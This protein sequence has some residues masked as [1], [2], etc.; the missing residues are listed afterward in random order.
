MVSPTGDGSSPAPIDRPLLEFLQTRLAS[1]QQVE[2][3][4]ITGVSG[5]LVLRVTL[6]ATYYPETVEE[7][8]LLIRWYTTT[9]LSSTTGRHTR[10]ATGS[11]AGI[12]IPTPTT[13]T[14]TF[15]RHQR[16]R[17]SAMT[18]PG[19]P[20][21]G[22]SYRSSSTASNAGSPISGTIDIHAERRRHFWYWSREHTTFPARWSTGR[23]E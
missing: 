15:T 17:R 8:R 11:V 1:T 21:I 9:I 12:A 5:H 2:R 10:T 18:P 16:L 22:I 3:T 20:I 4:D 6:A 7:A 13:H 19:H 23:N 14:I